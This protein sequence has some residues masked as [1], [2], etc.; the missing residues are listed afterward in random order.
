MMFDWFWEKEPPKISSESLT[1]WIS[2]KSEDGKC[3]DFSEY[4]KELLNSFRITKDK[5]KYKG[6][7]FKINYTYV[8]SS[9]GKL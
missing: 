7:F 2:F 6:I 4:D 8:R 9:F 1:R 5:I 3:V